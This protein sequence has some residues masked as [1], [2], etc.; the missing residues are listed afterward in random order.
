MT[1]PPHFT[2]FPL[3]VPA[4][5]TLPLLCSAA[6]FQRYHMLFHYMYHECFPLMFFVA[7]PCFVTLF[8]P[9]WILPIGPPSK[10]PKQRLLIGFLLGCS[11][12]PRSVGFGERSQPVVARRRLG[13]LWVPMPGFLCFSL[14]F[15]CRRRAMR[16]TSPTLA[17]LPQTASKK[18][19]ETHLLRGAFFIYNY[20][21]F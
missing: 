8:G 9:T 11:E 2:D 21:Y 13:F 17:F 10:F 4:A 5:F 3:A 14:G 6:A 19:F 12:L 7:K 16:T 20:S 18:R 1:L 15:L